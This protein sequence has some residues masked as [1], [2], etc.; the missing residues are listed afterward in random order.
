MSIVTF[1]VSAFYLYL[2]IG[3]LF[4]IWFTISGVNKIDAGMP[5]APWTV[6]VLIF[7]GSVLLWVVLLIKYLKTR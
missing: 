3:V 5:H 1:L 6:R 4:A 2:M 7:P